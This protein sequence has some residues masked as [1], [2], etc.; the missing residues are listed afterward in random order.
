MDRL[1]TQ[2]AAP[3]VTDINEIELPAADEAPDGI[4]ADLAA[5]ERE[6]ARLPLLERE[7][8]TL[9]YLRELSLGDV[10]EVLG[11]PVG[12]VKSRL[13]RARKLLRRE[14]ERTSGSVG[15]S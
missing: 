8:L 10:A 12:T 15:N 9:F 11:V 6:L 2:Y 13:F 3:T 14:I 4:E 5:V 1:R 7:V